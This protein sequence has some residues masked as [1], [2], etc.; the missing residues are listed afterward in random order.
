[1]ES[2]EPGWGALSGVR[3]LDLSMMLAGPYCT[4]ML[5]DQGAEVIKIE[6]PTGDTTRTLGPYNDDDK[7]RMFGGYFQSINRNKKG[8][9]LNLKEECDRQIFLKLVTKS[10]VLVENYRSGVMERLGL[11]YDSLI[12]QNPKLV[13]ACVR[14]FGDPRSG[15][16]PYLQWPA[17]DVVAQAMG[18]SMAIT[19][20]R[21]GA[22]MKIGPGIG[23]TVPAMML[24]F[25]ILA[26]LRHSERTGEGQFVDIAM[27]D[28]MIALCERSIYQYSYTGKAPKPE[29]NN[30]PLLCPFGI[31]PTTDGWVSIAAH[32]ENFW[33]ALCRHMGRPEL[34]T[35]PSYASNAARLNNQDHV[36]S[37]VSEWTRLR[38]KAEV[39]SIL[40]GEVPVGPVNNA[41]DIIKDPHTAMRG[42]LA[43]VDQP[44]STRSVVI[45]NTP[46][47][48]SSTPG[49]V[50]N[51]AP[52]LDEHRAQI[53]R[54]LGLCDEE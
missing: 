10:D 48:F 30:H 25:G 7:E 27:Y 28:G 31:F 24:A 33:S 53:F 41:E 52:M 32:Q 54:S 50:R 6:P 42:M 9:V 21:D 39:A 14:G 20:E 8:I 22:P 1:M 38:T 45:A 44:G 37:V 34:A 4:M 13:Y 3:V 26:A 43:S 16:S 17:Y 5:A 12:K 46:L 19:G 36:I 49:G 40:G 23:D 15:A 51:R 11:G 29:G 18:G 35:D 2:D 47:R